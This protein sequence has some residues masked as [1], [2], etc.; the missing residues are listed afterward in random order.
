MKMKKKTRKFKARNTKGMM[1]I[2]S[3]CLVATVATLSAAMITTSLV[4]VKAAEKFEQRMIAFHWAEGAVDKTLATLRTNPLYSGVPSTS[5]SGRVGGAYLSSVTSLGNGVYKISATGAVSGTTT[6]T[7]QYRTVEAYVNLL[8]Q[9]PLDVALFAH[10]TINMS[11]NGSIDAYDSRNGTYSSQT[12]TKEGHVGSNWNRGH[13]VVLSGNGKLKGNVT[14]GP[15]SDLRI[16]TV[17]SGNGGITGTV[18]A[19][20]TTTV[21]SAVTVSG[22]NLGSISIAGNDVQTL[23][24]GTYSLSSLKITGNGKIKLSG[25]TTIYVSGD[26]TITGNGAII[27]A[28]NLP[29]NLTLNVKGTRPVSF[30]GNGAF[31]GKIY[32]PTSAINLSGNGHIY[33]SIV[34]NTIAHSGNG[35]I[36]YDKALSTGGGS[37]SSSNNLTYW[38]EL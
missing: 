29:S 21:L 17:V 9:S 36:H 27:T 33:G 28:S 38:T 2:S 5:A 34:A 22:T 19:A 1:L 25:P 12:P 35:C 16:A 6:V 30:S 11:G 26:V 18:S 37:T 3:L 13:A 10:Q 4:E 24:P 14:V 32:A 15:S 31:Y 20:S 23:A 7:S 8:T